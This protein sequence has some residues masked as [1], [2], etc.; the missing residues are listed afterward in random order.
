MGG[1]L[2]GRLE[3]DDL[4]STAAQNHRHL[5]WRVERRFLPGRIGEGEWDIILGKRADRKGPHGQ[6]GDVER[7]V[8]GENN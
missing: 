3:S 5:W 2:C 7:I 6:R 4:G 8:D 1:R